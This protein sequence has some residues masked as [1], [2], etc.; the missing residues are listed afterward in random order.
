M[1]KEN[2]HPHRFCNTYRYRNFC[3]GRWYQQRSTGNFYSIFY[4]SI[5]GKLAK[6]E[7]L[8]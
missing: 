2:Y 8:L 4:K 3:C 6:R 1:K 7:R 5:R